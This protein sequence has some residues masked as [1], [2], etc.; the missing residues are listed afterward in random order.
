[1]QTS[2]GFWVN[3]KNQSWENS[4]WRWENPV[5]SW[6]ELNDWWGLCV[7]GGLDI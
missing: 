2:L 1:M 3:A 7:V 5:Y 4:T 6:E